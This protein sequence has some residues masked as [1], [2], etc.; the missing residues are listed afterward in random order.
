MTNLVS[1]IIPTFNRSNELRRCLMSLKSQ[2]FQEFEVLVCDDGSTDDTEDLVAS[3]SNHLPI[4]YFKLE[5]FGGPA[6]ARNVGIKNANGVYIAFLDSDD[7]WCD[8]KLE[9]SV[10]TLLGGSDIVYHDM[11]LVKYMNQKYFCRKAKSRE[12]KHPVLLDL[13]KN[14]N[15]INNS[16]VVVRKSI[17]DKVGSISDEKALIAWEDFDYWIKIAMLTDKFYR[18]NVCLGYY[19]QGG[20]NISGSTRTTIIMNLIKDRYYDLFLDKKLIIDGSFPWWIE[21]ALLSNSNLKLNQLFYSALH[22]TIKYK[23][24]NFLKPLVLKILNI[25]NIRNSFKVN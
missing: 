15:G 25:I 14:G 11:Y 3:F 17:V 1:V 20:G 16:S 7:W 23:K 24:L 2:T 19:W 4:R 13:L 22:F 5:N 8:Q 6:R 18:I 10:E 21:Y 9:L 12:L